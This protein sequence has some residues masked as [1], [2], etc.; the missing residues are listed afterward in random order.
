MNSIHEALLKVEACDLGYETNF[1]QSPYR[2]TL[3]WAS[4]AVRTTVIDLPLFVDR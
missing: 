2:F 3:V 1:L 4:S